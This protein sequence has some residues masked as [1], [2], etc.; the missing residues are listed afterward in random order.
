ME[1]NNDKE[2]QLK[3]N[4]SQN[5]EEKIENNLMGIDKKIENMKEIKNKLA[6]QLQN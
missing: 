5:V 1:I 4:S 2:I 3:T 6:E